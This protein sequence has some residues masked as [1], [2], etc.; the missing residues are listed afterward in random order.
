MGKTFSYDS[1]I[2]KGSDLDTSKRLNQNQTACV[3]QGQNNVNASE[4]LDV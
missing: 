3:G 1:T 4:N 2:I